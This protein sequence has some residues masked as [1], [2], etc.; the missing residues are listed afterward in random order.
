MNGNV[1]VDLTNLNLASTGVA[2]VFR[3]AGIRN[4]TG[5]LLLRAQCRV[6]SSFL[7]IRRTSKYWLINPARELSSP[8]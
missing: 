3:Y 2:V 1:A 8:V 4:G 7:T 6:A 5:S